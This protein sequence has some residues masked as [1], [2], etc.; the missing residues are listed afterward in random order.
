M[1]I[2]LLLFFFNLYL[3]MD[4]EG[5]DMDGVMAQVAQV[6]L[7]KG[8]EDD[9]P[10]VPVTNLV[11][12][13]KDFRYAI[14]GRFLTERFIRKTEMSLVLAANWHPGRGVYIEEIKPQLFLFQFG[15]EADDVRIIDGNPWAYNNHVLL[16]ERV[17]ENTDPEQI[18]LNNIVL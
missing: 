14:V 7:E 2:S 3:C 9:G 17:K 15:H 10:V 12:P 1:P 11:K 8:D 6:H 5:M 18:Q 4:H 16:M 13:S